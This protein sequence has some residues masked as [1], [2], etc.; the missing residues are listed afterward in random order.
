MSDDKE[1]S[2]LSSM[3]REGVIVI[4]E[5]GRD[6]YIPE[7]MLKSKLC[8]DR[9]R[10]AVKSTRIKKMNNDDMPEEIWVLKSKMDSLYTGTFCD[11]DDGGVK[12]IRAPEPIDGLDEAVEW[13]NEDLKQDRT[14][15]QST[16]NHIGVVIQ[17][18][19]AYAE[20]TKKDKIT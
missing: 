5:N 11:E 15:T 20:L 1:P 16:D 17:A 14:L 4:K 18:A 3:I 7:K 10:K 12:Y 9:L 19:K 2:F 13:F 6:R 8:M